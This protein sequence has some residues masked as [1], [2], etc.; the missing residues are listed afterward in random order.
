MLP[1]ALF[2]VVAFERVLR[3]GAA[4]ITAILVANHLGSAAFGELVIIIG[5]TSICSGFATLGLDGVLLRDIV[6]KPDILR[7]AIRSSI[8]ARSLAFSVSAIIAFSL[9][10]LLVPTERLDSALLFAASLPFSSLET[11]TAALQAQN[12][13][14]LGAW[15]RIVSTLLLVSFRIAA[16]SFDASFL[17]VA[18]SFAVE[19]LL[20]GSALA[21]AVYHA[22]GLGTGPSNDRVWL[23][24][25]LAESWSLAVSG[26]VIVIYMRFTLLAVGA[27]FGS[28]AAGVF[29]IAQRISES[30]LSL[31]TAIIQTRSADIL[32][33]TYADS[34][35]TAIPAFI[36]EIYRLSLLFGACAILLG[37]IVTNLAMDPHYA[38]AT[39]LLLP[40]SISSVFAAIGM[41]RSVHM[42]AT[43]LN[44]FHLATTLMGCAV[45]AAGFAALAPLFGLLG[46]SCAVALGY[47]T[48]AWLSCYIV[49]SLRPTGKLLTSVLF[50]RSM[51]K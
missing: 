23:R 27:L 39:P 50:L 15:Y 47:M 38:A 49:P 35:S 17:W 34:T 8:A 13:L 31:A 10:A 16:I 21:L 42:S 29:S 20:V 1:R 32:R 14:R 46:A 40:L 18:A 11:L 7:P 3:S 9:S 37:I 4:F 25:A 5:A 33:A 24:G 45:S 6:A 44:K 51:H 22:G 30:W 41:T 28:S 26:Q 43:R 36:A 2:S 12:Q 19:P 48:A